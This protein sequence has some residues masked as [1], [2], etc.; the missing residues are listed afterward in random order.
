[1]SPRPPPKT[2]FK[3]NWMKELD[4]EVAGSSKDTQRTISSRGR[5]EQVTGRAG[6]STDGVV[7]KVPRGKRRSVSAPLVGTVQESSTT[8]AKTPGSFNKSSMGRKAVSKRRMNAKQK[9]PTKSGTWTRR[10]SGP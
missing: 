5:A 2:S 7:T 8:T 4:S 3:D 6:A 9:Q 10:R 1:M